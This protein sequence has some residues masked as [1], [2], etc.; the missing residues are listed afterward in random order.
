M[1]IACVYLYLAVVFLLLSS[2]A[3]TAPVRDSPNLIRGTLV[4]TDIQNKKVTLSISGKENTYGLTDHTQ[5][6][7]GRKTTQIADFKIGEQVAAR[8]RNN[9]NGA[10]TLYELT[11]PPGMTWLIHMRRD[12]IMAKVKEATEKNVKVEE[13]EDRAEFIYHVGPKSAFYKS[14]HAAAPTD[15]KPGD[16]IWIAPRLLPGGSVMALSASDT[17]NE[18]KT[19]KNRNKKTL[20]GVLRIITSGNSPLKILSDDGVESEWPLAENCTVYLKSKSVGI[21]ALQTGMRVTL[22]F[23]DLP[24]DA[25]SI[26]RITI[27]NGRKKAGSPSSPAKTTGTKR[28]K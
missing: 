26:Q 12:I 20:R 19:I 7:R 6:W 2:K 18:L 8:F 11:D 21:T 4:S 15:F 14:G 22:H 13:G 3:L 23:I 5:F 9:T 27:V 10:P 16:T 17:E 25:K 1:K 24:N 28:K